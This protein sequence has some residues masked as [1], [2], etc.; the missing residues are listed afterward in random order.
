MI[1]FNGPG[2][3]R[4]NKL[5]ELSK[6]KKNGGGDEKGKAQSF[7]M[8]REKSGYGNGGM[9]MNERK[10]VRKEARLSITPLSY[11]SSFV[12][13]LLKEE[14]MNSS[15]LRRVLVQPLHFLLLHYHFHFLLLLP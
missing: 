10:K 3:Y 1:Y 11:L 15:V 9:R 4:K 12:L 5:E 6:K 7:W 13:E 2:Q 8:G 14:E